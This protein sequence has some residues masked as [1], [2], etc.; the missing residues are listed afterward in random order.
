MFLGVCGS[1]HGVYKE[2]LGGLGRLLGVSWAP[3]RRRLS[4]SKLSW[5]SLGW[6]L[7]PARGLLGILERS[8][9]SL[10]RLLGGSWGALGLCCGSKSILDIFMKGQN[11]VCVIF[12]PKPLVFVRGREFYGQNIVG[13]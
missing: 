12:V 1:A 2:G 13:F 10:G 5:R 9:E 4:V 8:G 7:G 6:L 3:L 11:R